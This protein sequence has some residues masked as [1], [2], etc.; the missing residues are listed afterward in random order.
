MLSKEEFEHITADPS[1]NY[2][3]PE[4]VLQDKQLTKAQKIEVLK[5]WAFDAQE[6]EK[7]QEENM[8]GEPSPLRQILLILHKLENED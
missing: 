2:A 1:A 4:D 7:A 3:K 8:K 6:I 5:L